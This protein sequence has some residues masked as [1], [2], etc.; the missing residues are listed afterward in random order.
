M[1]LFLIPLGYRHVLLKTPER[2]PVEAQ[3][4]DSPHVKWIVGLGYLVEEIQAQ[5]I[6]QRGPGVVGQDGDFE[7][8]LGVEFA[9]VVVQLFEAFHVSGEGAVVGTLDSL[10]DYFEGC[11]NPDGDAVFVQKLDVFGPSERAAA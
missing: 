10:A 5:H 7:V 4:V 3:G 9:A 1:G 11:V 2:F 8:G 6:G